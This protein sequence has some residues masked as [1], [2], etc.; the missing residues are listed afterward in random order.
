MIVSDIPGLDMV[1][2]HQL[3]RVVPP[4]D[5]AALASATIDLLRNPDELRTI[6]TRARAIAEEQF[7][8]TQTTKKIL[9]VCAKKG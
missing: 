8:W 5:V 9:E 1:R 4:G 2:T 7:T 6:A 3:G